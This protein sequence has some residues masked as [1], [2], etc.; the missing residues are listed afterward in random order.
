MTDANGVADKTQT[1]GA[2]EDVGGSK[3]GTMAYRITTTKVGG[4]VTSWQEDRGD[5]IRRHKELDM[6]GSTQ[7]TEIYEPYRTRVDEIPAHVVA[8]AQW[9][10]MYTEVVTDAGGLTT[11]TPKTETWSVDATEEQVT[12]PA[13][14]F[15]ALRVHRLSS[16]PSGPGSDKMFWFTR[17]VGKIKEVGLGQTEELVSR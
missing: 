10:E 13:G 16:T 1:V 9:T 11:S 3:A 15:C 12:V 14:T 17:G 8:G 7:T 5:S 4:S 6:A 2:L